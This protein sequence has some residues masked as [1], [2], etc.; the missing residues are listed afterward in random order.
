LRRTF[1]KDYWFEYDFDDNWEN[2]IF[3]IVCAYGYLETAE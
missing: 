1:D 2:W 3:V